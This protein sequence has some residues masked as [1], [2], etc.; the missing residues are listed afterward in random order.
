MHLLFDVESTGLLR[1]GSQL[2]CIVALPLLDDDAA[3]LVFDTVKDNIDEGVQL[4]QEAETLAGH[5]I[6]SYDLPLLRELY[7][8]FKMPERIHDT[9]IFSRLYHPDLA[10]SDYV[11]RPYGLPKK[12]YGSH[13]LK[14]WGIRIGEHKGDFGESN[15]WSTYSQEMLD[16]CIQ[17][18]MVN[19]ALYRKL[20]KRLPAGDRLN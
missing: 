16:Y 14:A 11:R 15:D 5:N 4:L 12:L 9:L 10:D 18:C 19:L 2:H 20:Y 17:D 6:V 8:D 7:P 1:R 13:G 3:P